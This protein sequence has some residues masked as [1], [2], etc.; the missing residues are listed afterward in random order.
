[1]VLKIEWF[2]ILGDKPLT[3]P[4]LR[5][6]YQALEL[7]SKLRYDPKNKPKQKPQ[8]TNDFLK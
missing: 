1:M 7:M 2:G 4:Y 5:L 6:H 3:I 8:K